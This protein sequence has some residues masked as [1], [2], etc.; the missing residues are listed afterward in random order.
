MYP[1]QLRQA[2]A[3]TKLTPTSP[4]AALGRQ[5][6]ASYACCA[7]VIQ[8]GPAVYSDGLNKGQ[9]AGI[10][11]GCVLFGL[12]VGALGMLCWVKRKRLFPQ[13]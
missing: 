7:V 2:A 10:V 4:S 3:E 13:K 8:A 9:V 5:A 12:L 1:T 6:V 11:I